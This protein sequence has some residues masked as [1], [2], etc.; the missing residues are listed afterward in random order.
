MS[1]W[2]KNNTYFWETKPFFRILLPFAAG[3]LCYYKGWLSGASGVYFLY[4]AAIAFLLLAVALFFEKP[5]RTNTLLT[6]ILTNVLLFSG[7]VSI[8]YYNDDSNNKGWF[9]NHISESK[10]YAVRISASPAEKEKSWKLPVA[11]LY[12]TDNGNVTRETGKAVVYIEKGPATE[13]L[14]RGDTLLVPG[15]WELIRNAGN[16]FEFDYA[17]YCA[18]NNLM[19]RQWCTAKDV[20]LYGK[21]NAAAA[22]FTERV[23]DWCMNQLSHHLGNNKAAGLLQAMLLGDEVNLDEDLR[24][25]YSQTGIVHIIAISGGNVAIFF[26]VISFLLGWVKHKKH[27]WVKYAIALPV[28]WFYVLMAGSQPSA[29]RAAGMFSLLAVGIML[30]KSNNSINQLLATAFVLL[31]AEPAWLFSVGFQLSFIAVL[32][33]VLFYKHIYSWLD[34]PTKK[35]KGGHVFKKL[36][37]W[38][39]DIPRTIWSAVAMSIAAE[40]LIAPIVIYYFHTFPVMFVIAN[41]AALLFMSVVLIL[42]MVLVVLS[43]LALLAGWLAAI[44]IWLVDTFGGIV[45]YLQVIGPK[46]FNILTLSGFELIMMYV[47]IAGLAWYFIRHYKPALFGGLLAV[48]LLLL[49]TCIAEWSRLQQNRLV[50]YNIKGGNRIE[51]ISGKTYSVVYTDTISGDAASYATSQAHIYWGV[52]EQKIAVGREVFSI[53]NKTVLLLNRNVLPA[54]RFKV[55]YLIL[56]GAG[57]VNTQELKR[58]FSPEVVVIGNSYTHRQQA[59]IIADC[60]SEGVATYSIAGQGALVLSE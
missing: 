7:G 40:I 34:V 27:L 30:Q 18:R 32:S 25:S 29:V 19:Y 59:A 42:G 46:S 4:S 52:Q 14:H 45:Y 35:A 12:A 53:N 60:V 10:V 36:L 50:V 16:P 56:N 24:Q 9:G 17:K 43:N 8:T 28:V 2:P 3:I 54:G 49:F 33:I 55:D 37:Q 31:F 58:V 57:R 48:C 39:Y 51:L 1:R 44:I 22:P 21:G 6:F 23:H 11:V 5:N 38:V 41:V 47:T 26:L 13:A 15:N 20:L